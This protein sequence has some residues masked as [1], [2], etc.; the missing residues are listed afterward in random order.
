MKRT[1]KLKEVIDM[2]LELDVQQRD[3]ILA[4]IRRAALAQR[5]VAK[6]GKK[7]GALKQVRTVEDHKI[8]RAYGTIPA[9]AK[10][11]KGEQ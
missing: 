11:T 4:D 10:K 8:V 2:L 7:A 1:D 5:I 6:A 3:K 9:R